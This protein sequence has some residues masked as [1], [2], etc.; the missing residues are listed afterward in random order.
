LLAAD[1]PDDR[2]LHFTSPLIGAKG[3]LIGVNSQAIFRAT[4]YIHCN[5]KSQ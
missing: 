3:Q 2:P 4:A 5:G 1:F